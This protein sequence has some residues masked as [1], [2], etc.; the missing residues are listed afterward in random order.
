V[1]TRAATPTQN[2]RE[3]WLQLENCKANRHIYRYMMRDTKNY[4]E[5]DRKIDT[6]TD[7]QTDR[8]IQS[9]QMRQT[10]RR[11]VRKTDRHRHT[12]RQLDR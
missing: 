3:W 9:Q 8:Y 12:D 7:K 6:G 11:M 4:I 5:I 2:S 10:R 1:Y